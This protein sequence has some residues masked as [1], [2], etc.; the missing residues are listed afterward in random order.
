M[1]PSDRMGPLE[2]RYRRL[3][4]L[5]PADHRAARG[6]ELLG[7]LLD[8]DS[9]RTRPSSRQAAGVVGLALRLRL[10]RAASLLFT[11]FLV[12]FSTEIAAIA[13]QVG[14][15][16]VTIGVDSR[17]LVQHATLTLLI[18]ALLRLAIAVAWVLGAPR[19]TWV[20]C[21]AL[22]AY[23]GAEGGLLRVDL[24]VLV[25]LGAAAAL[26]WWPPRRSRMVLLASIPLAML[27]WTLSA[28]WNMDLL[29]S[30]LGITA[31]VVLLGTVGRQLPQRPSG[32]GSHP[33]GPRGGPTPVRG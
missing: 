28:A 14:T 27:S 3:L 2:R 9:G 13:Y 20:A 7:L 18:P 1:G 6:E 19:T 10:P 29:G 24:V 26:R 32:G 25:G 23:S 4:R 31:V 17:P 11:A 33:D 8:L 16:A 22:L 21:A 12:A 5:L 30:L 15:S